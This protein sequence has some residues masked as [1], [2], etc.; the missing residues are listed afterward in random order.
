MTTSN[1][2]DSTASGILVLNKPT[3]ITSR[4]LVDQV[5]RLLPRTKVGHAGTLDPLATGILIVCVGAATRL[6]ENV[7]DLPKTYR[8]LIRLGARSDTLD[9][10][11][12]IEIEASPNVPS[13]GE[14]QQA[15]FPL[16]GTVMQQPPAFS[17]IKIQGKRAYDLA[18]AGQTID[19]TPRLVRIDRIGVIDYAWPHLELEIECGGGTYIRSIARDVG[20]A[21]GC[22]G[23][24]EALVRTRTGPF[25]L[26]LAIDP[27]ALSSE[28]IQ[29]LLRPALDAVPTL[30][31]LE[32]DAGQIEAI[33]QGKRLRAQ[34][35]PGEL[36]G[37]AGQVA[38]LNSEGTLI[39]L[40]ELEPEQG[41]L[42][43]RKVLA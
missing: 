5:A 40:G 28:S 3:G 29:G 32:L 13:S 10:D 39:A 7:Q 25:T 12:R 8:T 16:A 21:L 19:L 42:Q 31:R 23:Y 4:K 26:E 24:V 38:L 33:T 1:V 36:T 35:L 30:P 9:A 11:G 15:I 18:R 43:P 34:D 22:G 37:L 17:A 2:K 14:I 41:W 27:Q 6:V 20:D